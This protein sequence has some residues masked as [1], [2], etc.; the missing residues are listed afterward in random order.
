[1]TERA[2]FS[3]TPM[4]AAEPAKKKTFWV[5]FLRWGND[6]GEGAGE[7]LVEAM[8]IFEAI[9]TASTAVMQGERMDVY[10]VKVGANFAEILR[11]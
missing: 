6:D 2:T 10:E 8:D 5:V 9:K 1:M 7:V 3:E 4:R 11:S